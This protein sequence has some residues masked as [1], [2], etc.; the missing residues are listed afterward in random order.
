MKKILIILDGA[1]DLPID[2]L[3]EKTPLEIAKTPNL[4]FFAKNGRLG[5]MYPIN[6]TTIPSSDNALI[7]I[8]GN[9]PR[10]CKRGVYEAIGAGF[11]LKK[12]DLAVRINFGTIENLKTKKIIDRRTGRTLMTKEAKILTEALNKK[13]KLPC[14]FEIKST[15]QHRG[16][17]VLRGGFSDNVST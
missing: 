6:K 3:R 11:K 4:D 13:I 2:S 12:G 7:S 1:S 5:Y 9:D 15:I 10:L 16:V 14:R 17:L 8:F